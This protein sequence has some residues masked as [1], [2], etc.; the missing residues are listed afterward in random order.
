[1]YSQRN[2]GAAVEM[3]SVKVRPVQVTVEA[4]LTEFQP[5]TAD[6]RYVLLRFFGEVQLEGRYST[7]L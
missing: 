3:R 1:M 6:G 2:L 4:S 5:W 7:V